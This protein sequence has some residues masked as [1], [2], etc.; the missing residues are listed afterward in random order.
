MSST[1]ALSIPLPSKKPFYRVLYVQVLFAVAV[2]I[3]LGHFAPATA[4]DMK[5]LGDAFIKLVKMV[6]P[7]V[8]FFTVV[9]GIAGMESLKKVGRIGGKALIYFEV[10]STL[11][12]LIGMIVGNFVQPGA[13]FNADPAKLDAAAVAQYAGKAKDQTIVEFLMNIIPGTFV[14]AFAKGDML[15][16]ILVSLITGY[17]LSRLGERGKPIKDLFS[18]TSEMIFGI[19][20][21]LMRFAPLG[22]FGAMAFTIGRYGVCC[23]GTALEVDRH[24]LSYLRNI[25]HCGAWHYRSNCWHEYFPLPCLH[26]GRDLDRAGDKLV[27][28]GSASLNGEA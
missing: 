21:L 11:A 20:N 10:V 12:L 6:I 1:A 27:G 23:L 2:G 15:P 7:L 14:D 4:V 13:G 28:S 5:P 26:Q 24:V 22:A 19:V 25:R 17:A 9:S 18:V 3:V 8:I 16:V